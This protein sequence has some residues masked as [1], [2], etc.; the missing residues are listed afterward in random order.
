MSKEH[1]YVV[2][3]A[4]EFITTTTAAATTIMT[5]SSISYDVVD[6]T[7]AVSQCLSPCCFLS[8]P[9]ESYSVHEQAGAE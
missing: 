2:R 4:S 8:W 6:G 3:A 5:T 9:L 1:A 7:T